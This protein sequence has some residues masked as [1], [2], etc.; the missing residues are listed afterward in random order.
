MENINEMNKRHDKEIK[1]LQELCKHKKSK[2][3][4]YMWAPGHYGG[5]VETCDFCGKILKR[6]EISIG[7]RIGPE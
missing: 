7:L 1:Q 5:D 2:W 3:M 6:K 4:P